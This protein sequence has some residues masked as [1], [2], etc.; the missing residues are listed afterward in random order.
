VFSENI[1]GSNSGIIT[2][3]LSVLILFYISKEIATHSYE[4]RLTQ[5]LK[6]SEQRFRDISVSVPGVIYQFCLNSE[7]GRSFAFVSPRIYDM[8]GIKAEN[9]M[10][11]AEV[12]FSRIH[13][14][15]IQSLEASILESWQNMSIW[16]WTGRI[17]T[18]D[19]RTGWCEGVSVPRKI[20]N[21]T[22]WNGIVLDITEKKEAE[23]TLIN[24][25]DVMEC[26]VQERTKE[27]VAAKELAEESA[28]TKSKF[29]AHMSHE[30]RTPLNAII[31]FSQLL[32]M[33]NVT[34]L[35][36]EYVEEISSAGDH[37]LALVN[38]LL[39]LEKIEAGKM[40]IKLEPV[41]VG[42]LFADVDALMMP[43]AAVKNI[44]IINECKDED[45][46][47]LADKVRLRQVLLNLMSNAIKYN[48][49]NG[50]ITVG[51][52]IDGDYRRIKVTDTG[53]GVK[54]ES[55]EKLFEPFDRLGAE[56]GITNGTG[57]G[58]A[59]SKRLAE[60]M[61]GTIGVESESGRGSTFW[62][63]LPDSKDA[64]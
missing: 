33:G 5:K 41:N 43:A 44:T 52:E 1:D 26:M 28:E 47:V 14:D 25:Y 46:F 57:I 34:A 21:E 17:V 20:N 10:Q 22:V 59:I 16:N 6:E 56:A 31:G 37:L 62:V 45:I 53:I 30:F 48:L 49:E 18:A 11:D 32:Q 58:L 12:W 4:E 23:L 3:T 8:L 39:D 27:L 63:R 36:S 35:Q 55:F 9:I 61:D 29:L 19:G 51:C 64:G 60:M 15:D 2:G 40:L 42:D 24:S 54:Q 7:G 38:D 13:P 50:A